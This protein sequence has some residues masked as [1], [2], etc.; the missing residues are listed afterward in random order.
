[1]DG[2]NGTGTNPALRQDSASTLAVDIG[3]SGIKAMLLD[4]DGVPLSAYLRVP[5]PSP[6]APATV[7][8]I[9]T[10]LAGG[11]GA[12]DRVSVGFPG[13]VQRGRVMSAHLDPG[14]IGLQFDTFLAEYLGRP[15]R[16]ANDADIQGLAA[17]AGSGI[18]LVLTLGTGL[19]SALFMDGRLVPNVQVCHQPFRSGGTYE[20]HLGNSALRTQGSLHWNAS[21]AVALND[22]RALFNFESCYIGGG[23]ARKVRLDL[24]VN[25]KLTKNING[26]LGGIALWR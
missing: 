4:G 9:I 3:G 10:K 18:E 12:F 21:L 11:L 19:G 16:V 15:V 13:V 23:N 1:M 25:V 22:L 24:P 7:V 17:I 2:Y 8:Q 14:W 20:E 6:A 5:T 26:V